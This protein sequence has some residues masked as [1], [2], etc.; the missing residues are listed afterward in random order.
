[1][2]AISGGEVANDRIDLDTLAGTD[3]VVSRLTP[4]DIPLVLDV[5]F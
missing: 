3:H 2:L 1:M 5:P 4:A